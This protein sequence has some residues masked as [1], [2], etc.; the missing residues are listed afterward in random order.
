VNEQYSATKSIRNYKKPVLIIHST[1]DD[2][3]PFE[4]GQKLFEH[5]NQPK[6]FYEI[7]HCH[8]CGPDFYADSISQK[9]RQL[10]GHRPLNP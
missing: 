4:M 1:E 10:V 9:I 7:K 2:V 3:I 8:M 5:A 6:E